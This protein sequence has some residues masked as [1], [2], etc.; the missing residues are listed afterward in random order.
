MVQRQK[1]KYAN[2]CMYLF[3]LLHYIRLSLYDN[4]IWDM[5]LLINAYCMLIVIILLD[6][7]EIIRLAFLSKDFFLNSI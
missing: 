7:L 6:S 3:C 5:R 2:T 4:I 1:K